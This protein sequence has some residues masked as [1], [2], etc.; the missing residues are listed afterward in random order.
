MDRWYRH[1]EHGGYRDHRNRLTEFLWYR[2]CHLHWCLSKEISWCPA[3]D[4]P[5]QEQTQSQVG[6][7]S[8]LQKWFPYLPCHHDRYLPG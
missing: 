5:L 6:V 4:I 2:L 8:H 7:A 3:K 1:G